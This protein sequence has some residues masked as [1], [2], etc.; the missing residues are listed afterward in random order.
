MFA[1]L[2]QPG[3]CFSFQA[4]RKRKAP[5]AAS[6]AVSS[7]SSAAAA[8]TAAAVSTGLFCFTGWLQKFCSSELSKD[9]VTVSVLLVSC[10]KIA[11]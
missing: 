8:A 3:L 4:A 5:E 11:G 2:K 1:V 7:S 9:C 6:S 10:G